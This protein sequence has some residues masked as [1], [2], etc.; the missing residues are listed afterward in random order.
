VSLDPNPDES[1][2]LDQLVE[3][4]P[5]SLRVRIGVGAGILLLIAAL[6]IAVLVS[7]FAPQG[8][9]ETLSSSA[10]AGAG[11]SGAGGSL[12]TVSGAPSS[13]GDSVFVHVLGAVRNPGLFELGNGA[14]VIDAVSAA[15]GFTDDAEQGGVNLARIMA[16]GEQIVV[17]RIG[18]AP[19]AAVAGPTGSGAAAAPPGAKV[20][21]NSGAAADFETLPRIGPAMAQRIVDWRTANGR[22]SRIEDLM[23]VT[24]I[25]QKTFDSLKDL[26]TL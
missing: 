10:V 25:G 13:S 1:E 11:G 23:N 9:A 21:L 14:R 4:P 15:G 8:H 26:I 22:F 18:E 12:P 3:P 6:V 2:R 7:V 16:D 19:P 24:G 20:S 5:R 17:P